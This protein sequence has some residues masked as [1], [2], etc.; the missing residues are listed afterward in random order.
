MPQLDIVE[1]AWRALQDEIAS[2]RT[3]IQN[4][5]VHYER[6]EYAENVTASA[7]ADAPLA[8]DGSVADGVSYATL[9][10]ISNGRKPGELAGAGTG[11]LCYYNASADQWWTVSGNVQ[12]TV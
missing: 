3:D 9:R 8:A 5:R 12:V 10:W 6:A 2:L 1:L 11:I 7:L 4:I